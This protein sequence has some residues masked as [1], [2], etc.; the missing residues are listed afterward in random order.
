VAAGSPGAIAGL[1]SGDVVVKFDGKPVYRIFDVVKGMGFQ[2]GTTHTLTV[3][4]KGSTN[5]EL[6]VTSTGQ[7]EGH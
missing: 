5:L 7:Q 3:A 6:R 2:V 4:R 1:R